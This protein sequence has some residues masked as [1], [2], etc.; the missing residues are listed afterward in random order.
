MRRRLPGAGTSLGA[1]HLNPTPHPSRHPALL[2]HPPSRQVQVV[3]EALV[4]GAPALPTND[5]FSGAVLD[6]TVAH[7]AVLE[8]RNQTQ[9][10]VVVLA[11]TL[12]TAGDPGATTCVA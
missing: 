4:E 11:N 1:L 6:V 12:T 5:T 8:F 3:G 2:H 10:L 7:E 9:D